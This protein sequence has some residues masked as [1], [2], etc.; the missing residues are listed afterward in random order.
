MGVNGVNPTTIS[1]RLWKSVEGILWAD[2]RVM[3]N[4]VINAK[5]I[6]SS[7]KTSLVQT[8]TFD[9]Y[10]DINGRWYIDYPEYIDSGFGTKANLEMVAGADTM[11]EHYAPNGK[12]RCT[13]SNAPLEAYDINLRRILV[14]PWGA[15]Y[16]MSGFPFKSVWL[17]N[18]SKFIFKGAHPKSLYIQIL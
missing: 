6:F 7:G 17:C 18:V 3:K 15:T 5:Y 13:F 11:L 1:T 12:A 4:E 14:D 9:F 10:R 8:Y 16:M 2:I